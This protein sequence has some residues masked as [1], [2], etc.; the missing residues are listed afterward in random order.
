MRHIRHDFN[1]S[2]EKDIPADDISK[3][4]IEGYSLLHCKR[5]II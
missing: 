1:I 3:T 5:L 2:F 4:V